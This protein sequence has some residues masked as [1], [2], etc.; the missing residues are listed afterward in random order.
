MKMDWKIVNVSDVRM[1]EPY[2]VDTIKNF[3]LSQPRELQEKLKER[4]KIKRDRIGRW[5][6]SIE[7]I[8]NFINNKITNEE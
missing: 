3:I 5:W 6:D 2:N 8:Q 1:A 7:E 4:E